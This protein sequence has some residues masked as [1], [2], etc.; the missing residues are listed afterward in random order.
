[1]KYALNLSDD[2]RI[3]SACVVLPNGKYYEMP[4]VDSLPE[5]NL[6]DHLY[7]DGDFIHDPLPEPEPEDPQ[8]T[9]EER[10]AQLEEELK[11]AKILLGLEV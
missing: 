7:I 2:N 9:A 1:M 3:L 11:A 6:S 8:P 10:I 4:I 5:G